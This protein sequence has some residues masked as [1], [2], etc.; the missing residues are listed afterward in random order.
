MTKYLLIG[1]A[2][3]VVVV[4]GILIIPQLIPKPPAP[5]DPYGR[6]LVLLAET[7]ERTCLVGTDT[8]TAASV[9][10]QIELIKGVKAAATAER[11]EVALRGA[12][13]FPEK[14]KAPEMAA[15][16]ACM[17]PFAEQMRKIADLAMR[18]G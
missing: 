1:V 4:L 3:L 10:S 5:D 11:R 12:I 14:L 2:A 6:Q 7:A 13:D 17:E 8:R 18:A 9:T 16:R 15:A